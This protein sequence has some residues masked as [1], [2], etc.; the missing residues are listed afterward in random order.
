MRDIMEGIN[1]KLFKVFADTGDMTSLQSSGGKA[2]TRKKDYL[3][4]SQLVNK[5]YQLQ[6]DL[7]QWIVA[8]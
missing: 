2:E 8:S 5:A 7:S 3:S 4:Q 1:E 6:Y